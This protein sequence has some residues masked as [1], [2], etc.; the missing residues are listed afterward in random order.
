M[1]TKPVPVPHQVALQPREKDIAPIYQIAI[2]PLVLV[3]HPSVPPVAT[4]P[5]LLKY[6]AANKGKVAYGSYGARVPTR[7][8]PARG[9]SQSQNADMEPRGLPG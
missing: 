1:L 8:W 2:A 7:T 6:I 4:G 3:A 5:E 9:M